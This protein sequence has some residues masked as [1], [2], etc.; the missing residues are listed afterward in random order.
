M[1]KMKIAKDSGHNEECHLF[2]EKNGSVKVP[3]NELR[4]Q[5]NENHKNCPKNL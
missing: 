2:P 4:V 3:G 1:E 5:P